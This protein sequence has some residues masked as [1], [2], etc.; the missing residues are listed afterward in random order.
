V[1]AL[2]RPHERGN[3]LGAI[4]RSLTPPAVGKVGPFLE[5]TCN[6]SGPATLS[7]SLLAPVTS[8]KMVKSTTLKFT[9][10]AGK[11]KPEQFLGGDRSTDMRSTD[12]M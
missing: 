8:G 3:P 6:G 10:M 12:V 5:Y 11:Q 2:H 4:G 1:P 9:A 7:G